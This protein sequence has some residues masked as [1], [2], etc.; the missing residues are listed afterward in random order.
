MY[1]NGV[2]WETVSVSAQNSNSLTRSTTI[3]YTTTGT[4]T[5]ALD[6]YFFNV[7][8]D[9]GDFFYETYNS[10]N[11]N[12]TNV[13]QVYLS[14][15]LERVVQILKSLERI[16]IYI[17]YMTMRSNDFSICTTLSHILQLFQSK[18]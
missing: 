6:Q 8:I 15:L 17:I 4:K 13:I 16:V 5:I 10:R 2:S 18:C 7:I 9:T 14:W 3:S 1:V 12:G 11:N